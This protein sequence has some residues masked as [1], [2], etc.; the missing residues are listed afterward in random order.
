MNKSAHTR[1]R[2]SRRK[3]VESGRK[4]EEIARGWVSKHTI[5]A[6]KQNTGD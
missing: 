1:R 3:Q 6:W 4:V 2:L 5:Y